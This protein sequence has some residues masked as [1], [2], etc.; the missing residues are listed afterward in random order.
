MNGD[1]TVFART[2]NS[3]EWT[4]SAVIPKLDRFSLP[5]RSIPFGRSVEK[6]TCL[7]GWRAS[8]SNVHVCTEKLLTIFMSNTSRVKSGQFG[9]SAKSGQR[10][11]LF[12]N[13]IIVIKIN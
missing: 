10:P 11:C 3:Y 13:L 12:H 9:R 4:N 2:G 1:V 5:F 7:P 6:K 8:F